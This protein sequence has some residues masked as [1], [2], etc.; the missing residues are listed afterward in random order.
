MAHQRG[1][2]GWAALALV[3]AGAPL[4]AQSLWLPASDPLGIARSGAGVAYGQSLEA[5]SLNPAL[6]PTLRSGGSAF[7]S[8]GQELMSTQVGLKSNSRTLF[9]TDRNRG[10][11]G[12]GAHWR[13]TDTFALGL[14][15]DTPFMS[16]GTLPVEGGVRYSGSGLDLSAR[17]GEIQLGWAFRPELSFGIGVG[18]AS[19]HMEERVFVR[20]P[21]PVDPTQPLSTS[22]PSI[23]LVETEL[24]QDGTKVLPCFSLGMRWAMSPRWT[25]GFGYQ[26]A[27]RGDLGGT[28]AMVG[29]PTYVAN[30]GYGTP[31][32]DIETS[33]AVLL[34]G[35]SAVAGATSIDL[36]ARAAL[37]IRQRLNQL[38]TWEADLRYV[39]STQMGL[40]DLPSLQTPSGLVVSPAPE[41]AYQAGLSLSVLGEFSVGQDWTIRAGFS[42]DPAYVRPDT[43]TGILNGTSSA[44]FSGGV[45]YRIWG[46][47]LS[48]GYQYRQGRDMDVKHLDG[49]WPVSGFQHSNS[50]NRL[51]GMGHLWAVGFRKAF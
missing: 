39:W 19:V 24:S 45:G 47:E 13:L 25:L 9:T 16:H 7:L 37:G 21:I 14:K 6:L 36:P 1:L 26:S 17:R 46:G 51:E 40:P 12:L 5:A 18:V 34:A 33:G 8:A 31:P 2:K 4:A 50:T 35:S 22:N 28:A 29:T 30:D 38:F 42:L 44:G 20:A 3:A 27:I 23:A 10:L 41:R 11:L 32:S 48:A 49:T 43:A 15:V